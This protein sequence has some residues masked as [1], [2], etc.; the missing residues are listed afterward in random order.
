MKQE[1]YFK[2]R[3]MEIKMRNL[4][5]KVEDEGGRARHGKAI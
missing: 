2:D 4:I 1:V 3:V 5:F